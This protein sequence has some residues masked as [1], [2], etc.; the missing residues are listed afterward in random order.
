MLARLFK[1][2]LLFT[3]MT[4]ISCVVEP[5]GYYDG[6]AYGYGY[7]PAPAYYPPAYG[8]YGYEPVYPWYTGVNVEF[9]HGYGHGGYGH[10][11]HRR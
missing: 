1:I 4:C 11:W 9:G 7:G 5:A 8:Y 3:V 6:P 2:S 10:R